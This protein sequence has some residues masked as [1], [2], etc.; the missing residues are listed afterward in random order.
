MSAGD[1]YF[2]S[3]IE[4]AMDLG[5]PFTIA[6]GANESM[7]ARCVIALDEAAARANQQIDLTLHPSGTVAYAALTPIYST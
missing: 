6:V 1:D 4:H 2:D 3:I 7:F 5:R